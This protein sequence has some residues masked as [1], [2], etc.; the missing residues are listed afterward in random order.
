MDKNE[1]IALVEEN[2]IGFIRLQFTD[3]NGILKTFAVSAR[4]IETILEDG[5]SF[6]GSSITGYGNIEES[7]MVAKP[8]PGTFA[9][10]PWREKE[11]ASARMICNVYNPDGSRY[12]GDPRYVAEKAAEKAKKSG[13]VFNVGPELEFFVFEDEPEIHRP[14][15][16][17]MDIAGYF[18]S[19]PGDLAEDMRRDMAE[20]AEKFGLRVEVAH[21]EVAP[22][23]HEIDFRYGDL[24][25]TADRTVTMRMLIKGIANRYGFIGTFMP[26]PLYGENGNGMHVHQSLWSIKKKANAFY[27]KESKVVGNLSSTALN[28]IGGRLKYGKEMIAVLASWPNSYKRL[29]PGYEAPVYTAWA[30]CNRSPLIRVPDVG[31]RPDAARV[32]IRCPDP[33]GNPYLQFAVLCCT[34]LEGIKQGTDP[35]KRTERNVYEMS[36]L[37]RREL[38]IESLPETFDHA[39]RAFEDSDLMREILGDVVFENFL[40]VKRSEWDKYRTHVTQWEI[41]RYLRLL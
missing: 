22:G 6:D 41:D 1:V 13:F 15:P 36:Y 38:G 16:M 31:N 7:D 23:Q 20:M 27:D 18:D 3:V 21:H 34:G 25:T 9:I 28:F 29:V 33:A 35:G 30:H 4:D 26:K 10:I 24:V 8:D 11:H 5:Q 40:K 32:E 12:E 39:L 17:D 14:V 37:E 2:K 19:H